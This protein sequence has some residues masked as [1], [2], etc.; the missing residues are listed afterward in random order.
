MTLLK[1]ILIYC[2]SVSVIREGR[3]VTFLSTRLGLATATSFVTSTAQ[4]VKTVLVSLNAANNCLPVTQF[5]A[6]NIKT[7]TV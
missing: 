4:G 3:L 6:A 7:C 2:L 1:L 5:L